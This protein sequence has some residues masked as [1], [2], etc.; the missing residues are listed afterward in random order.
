MSQRL[1]KTKVLSVFL[2][3]TDQLE[4]D[5][6]LVNTTVMSAALQKLVE[7]KMFNVDQTKPTET[8]ILFVMEIVKT[9][10]DNVVLMSPTLARTKESFADQDT[11]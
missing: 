8:T 9:T 3:P 4:L 11:T 7:T 5:A 1:A 2:E 6:T 10:K